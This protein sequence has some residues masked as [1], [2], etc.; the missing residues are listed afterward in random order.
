MPESISTQIL[1]VIDTSLNR[2]AE[3][4]RF[5]E[6]SARFILNNTELTKQLKNLSHLIMPHV[7]P[8][9]KQFIQSRDSQGDVGANEGA[10]KKA[11]DDSFTVISAILGKDSPEKTVR[12]LIK[13]F[14]V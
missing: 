4:L 12:T 3:V 10:V 14:E 5:Q 6:D 8:F 1:R 11:G 13:K 2:A 9:Q 7:W